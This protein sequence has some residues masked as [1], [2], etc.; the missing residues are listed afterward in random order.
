MNW[1]KFYASDAIVWGLKETI[2]NIRLAFLSTFILLSE[3]LISTIILGIP[4]L[5]HTLRAMPGL[6]NALYTPHTPWLMCNITQ[7][8]KFCM[9][10][11][12]HD[13]PTSVMIMWSFV[14]F[15]LT[16][17][18]SMFSAGYIRMLIKFHDNGTAELKQMFLGWHRGPRIFIAGSIL[19]IGFTIGTAFF[20]VPGVYI[21]VHAI[22]YPF[23]IVDK[24]TGIIESLKKSFK[25][26]KGHGWQVATLVLLAML[27]NINPMIK[28]LS[29]FPLVLML[30]YTYRRLA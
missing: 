17:L 24:D 29:G 30:I 7:A 3:M 13:I 15:A 22:L 19:F 9:Q 23:F 5:I 8:Q 12:I 14:F 27:V 1:Q 4:A 21:L 6:R 10:L 26:V 20:I 25:A 18:W 16:M 2:N 11:S 28:L